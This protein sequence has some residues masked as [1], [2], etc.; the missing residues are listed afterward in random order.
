MVIV[1]FVVSL[2]L[3]VA[4]VVLGTK[5]REAKRERVIR[6]LMFPPGLIDALGEKHP[7]L[8]L[9]DRQ[10]VAHA[11]RQFFLAY[12]RGKR[13]PVTMP[14]QVADDLWHGFILH[15]RAYAAFCRD[16]FGGFLHHTPAAALGG[17]KATNAG[18]R[19]V[20]WHACLEE[21]INPRKPTRL[22]LLFALD[23]KLAIAGGFHYLLDCR[24][25]R[26]AAAAGGA[27]AGVSVHCASDIS[28]SSIDGGTDGFGGDGGGSG[29]GGASGDGGDGGGGCGGE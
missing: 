24:P 9:K 21:N 14:S 11:L 8:T 23:R 4:L 25:A 3:L 5:L 7:Q 19:R 28:D 27:E 1:P 20:F 15:T 16:A 17:A 2:V 13:R 10:L 6:E 26:A 29:G 12:L 18:L 22:P